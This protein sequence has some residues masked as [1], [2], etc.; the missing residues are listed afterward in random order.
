MPIKYGANT[1]AWGNTAIYCIENLD[2]GKCYIGQ[3]RSLGAR[4]AVH[5]NALRHHKHPNQE[6]QRDYDRGHKFIFKALEFFPDSVSGDYLNAK[7]R[8][9]IIKY[10]GVEYGYNQ[11]L[12]E[13]SLE[14]KP[15]PDKYKV[16]KEKIAV[17][18]KTMTAE[19]I[20]YRQVIALNS[21]ISRARV[22]LNIKELIK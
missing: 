11:I 14:A 19:P 15:H 20:T 6:L 5:I 22:R 9:Y 8:A 10:N 2:N 17:A 4:R 21:A 7:E 18:I 16:D 13:S 12:P 3:S 1:G